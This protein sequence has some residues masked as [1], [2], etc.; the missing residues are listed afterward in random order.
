MSDPVTRTRRYGVLLRKTIL[1]AALL[2]AAVL[3]QRLAD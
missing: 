1:G 2:V 3:L